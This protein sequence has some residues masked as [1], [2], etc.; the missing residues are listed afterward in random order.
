[1]SINSVDVWGTFPQLKHL[2]RNLTTAMSES[3][4][5]E[6][7]AKELEIPLDTLTELLGEE[8]AK[9]PNARANLHLKKGQVLMFI[10]MTSSKGTWKGNVAYDNIPFNSGSIVH[11]I[12]FKFSYARV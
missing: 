3:L 12:V 6:D 8:L 2:T 4:P 10:H 9:A 11:S 7:I 5:L 1:M